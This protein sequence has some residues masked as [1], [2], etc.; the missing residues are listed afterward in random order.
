M[1]VEDTDPMLNGQDD[2]QNKKIAVNDTSVFCSFKRKMVTN[3]PFDLNIAKGD[4]IHVCSSKSWTTNMV[5]HKH[6]MFCFYWPVIDGF[7]G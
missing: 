6:S 4:I 7:D 1:P 2:L 5:K 3:D